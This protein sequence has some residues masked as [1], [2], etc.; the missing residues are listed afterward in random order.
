MDGDIIR[1][2]P[3]LFFVAPT[4]QRIAAMA[5]HYDVLC[6]IDEDLLWSNDVAVGEVIVDSVCS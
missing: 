4:I 2:N 3:L 5:I 6:E 1:H